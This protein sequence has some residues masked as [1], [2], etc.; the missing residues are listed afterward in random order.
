MTLPR[1]QLLRRRLDSL[2]LEPALWS[3]CMRRSRSTVPEAG[4]DIYPV[5]LYGGRLGRACGRLPKRIL[6]GIDPQPHNAARAERKWQWDIS[7]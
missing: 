1:L 3:L 6:A 5:C 2:G 4:Q 7:S